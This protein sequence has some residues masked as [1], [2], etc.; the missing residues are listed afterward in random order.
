MSSDTMWVSV[1]CCCL[2][3]YALRRALLPPTAKLPVEVEP[4]KMMVRCW[5][6]PIFEG[7]KPLISSE[8]ASE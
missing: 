5:K 6:H 8:P 7:V 4:F 3:L 1:L 2:L